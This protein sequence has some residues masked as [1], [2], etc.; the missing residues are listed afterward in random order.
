MDGDLLHLGHP[1]ALLLVRGHKAAGPGGGIFNEGAGK[2]DAALVGVADGVGGAGVGHAADEVDVLGH[3]LGLVGPGQA[4][5]VP[6]PHDLH[7]DAFVVGV[8]VAV[9]RPEEGAHAHLFL[10]GQQGL[11]AVLGD[12]HH[13]GG[14]QLVGV[15][16]A[17]LLVGKGLKGHAAALV[18]LADVDGQAAHLVPPGDEEIGRHN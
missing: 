7:V 10:G 11:P 6:V 5:A 18:V 2:G 16:I 14:T 13:L 3:A 15:V 8:G 17:H 9:V 12:L 4:R 1:V